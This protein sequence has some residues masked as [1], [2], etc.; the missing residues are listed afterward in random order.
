[1]IV[2]VPQFSMPFRFEGGAAAVVEQDSIDEIADCCANICR[3]QPGDRPSKPLFGMPDQTFSQ[4]AVDTQIAVAAV[5]T[6]E[7]RALL[8]ASSSI[9]EFV[10]TIVMQVDK[11]TG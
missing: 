3:Y 1:M 7:P 10:S 9:E 11:V 8:A 6:F 2:R 4:G 5:R